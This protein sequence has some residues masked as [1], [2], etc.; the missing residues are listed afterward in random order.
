MNKLKELLTEAKK[1]KKY[2]RNSEEFHLIQVDKSYPA[3]IVD[4]WYDKVNQ[5][6]RIEFIV[7]N[8]ISSARV[9]VNVGNC[10][11]FLNFKIKCMGFK[12]LLFLFKETKERQMYLL[13]LILL[14]YIIW[15]LIFP[16]IPKQLILNVFLSHSSLLYDFLMIHFKDKICKY[17]CNCF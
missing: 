13:F 11:H 1:N 15:S 17:I 3:L 2:R 6:I 12:H 4:A 5:K 14:I 8:Y 7:F 10:K 16:S 9:N